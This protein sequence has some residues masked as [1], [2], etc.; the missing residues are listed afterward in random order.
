MTALWMTL[1]KRDDQYPHLLEST[2]DLLNLKDSDRIKK[3]RSRR[4]IPYP[5]AIEILNDLEDLLVYPKTH[6][7]PNLLII[8]E[9]NNGKTMLIEHFK[10]KYPATDNFTGDNV[11]VPVLNIQAPPTP[12]ESRLYSAILTELFAPFR[13]NDRVDKKSAQVIHLLKM[14]DTKILIIDEIHS[15]LAGSVTKQRAFL[16]ALRHLGNDLRIPIVAVGT[17]EAHRAIRSDPQLANR[18]SPVRLPKWELDENYLRLLS[19]FEVMIPLKKPSNLTNNT[20][21]QKVREM[22]DGL[23]GEISTIIVNAAV[24]AI[25]NK[26]EC[27][28]LETL[29]S[30][31]FIPPNKRKLGS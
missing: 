22:S 4:W 15:I 17:N 29:N 3:I 28:S 11:N 8:G 20:I 1:M 30:L 21:V 9:T 27:I 24:E 31:R 10:K 2:A 7:M 25:R 12:D 13:Q 26:S 14:V 18:F 16:N 23:L 19:S 6:R 5:A